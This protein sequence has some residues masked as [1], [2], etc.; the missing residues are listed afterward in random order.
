MSRL[1]NALLLVCA[2]YLGED[3][4]LVARGG[5]VRRAKDGT[6]TCAIRHLPSGLTPG[7]L[8]RLCTCG[9]HRACRCRLGRVGELPGA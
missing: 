3:G 2:V 1:A 5:H 7:T 9:P 4:V 6:W 8:I